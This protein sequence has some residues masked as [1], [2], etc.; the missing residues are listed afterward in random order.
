VVRG[1][2]GWSALRGVVTS[3]ALALGCGG[4]GPWC[5]SCA[6]P[7]G[8]ATCGHRTSRFRFAFGCR[9][10]GSPP[11]FDAIA[12]PTRR[13]ALCHGTAT[14]LCRETVVPSEQ[15]ADDTEPAYIAGSVTPSAN[16]SLGRADADARAT[17]GLFADACRPQMGPRRPG[18]RAERRVGPYPDGYRPPTGPPSPEAR[19]DDQ[20]RNE[21]AIPLAL[22]SADLGAPG[23][24]VPG[25]MTAANRP[26]LPNAR[27]STPRAGRRRSRPRPRADDEPRSEVPTP[28]ALFA[29]VRS[30]RAVGRRLRWVPGRVRSELLVWSKGADNIGHLNNS[31]ILSDPSIRLCLHPIQ[32]P[33]ACY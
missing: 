4:V 26:T 1:G 21:Q 10:H 22:V 33:R 8:F 24:P 9:H 11:R 14:R 5:E 3:A 32:H 7:C 25:R 16:S 27:R 6:L 19:A 23:G 17:V 29:D 28:L 2:V 20:P 31:T 15:T 18:P 13:R 30:R 12:L